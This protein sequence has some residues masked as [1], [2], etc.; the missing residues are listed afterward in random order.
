M[1]FPSHGVPMQIHPADG[2]FA[3]CPIMGN[4]HDLVDFDEVPDFAIHE[5]A[6]TGKD[7]LPSVAPRRPR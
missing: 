3:S 5:A 2:K 1:L 6:D 7:E 4:I